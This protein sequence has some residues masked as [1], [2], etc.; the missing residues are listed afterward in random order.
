MF[1]R[2]HLAHMSTLPVRSLK[3]VCSDFI[4]AVWYNT[5]PPSCARRLFDVPCLSCLA[6][7]SVCVAIAAF[8]LTY[9]LIMDILLFKRFAQIQLS[10]DSSVGREDEVYSPLTHFSVKG[11]LNDHPSQFIVVPSTEYVDSI[12]GFSNRFITPDVISYSHLLCGFIAG[13]FL[14]SNHLLDRRI[15]VMLYEFRTWLDSLDGTVYRAQ[16]G[17]RL[18]Y[19]SNHS[20]SGYFIDSIFDTFGG[21]FLCLG[22][23]Y[24]LKKRFGVGHGELQANGYKLHS[25]IPDAVVTLDN[26]RTTTES[27]SERYLLWKTFLFGLSLAVAGKCWDLAV[28]DFTNVYEYQFK[29]ESSFSTMQTEYSHSHVTLVIFYLWRLC[30]GQSVLNY[31]LIAIFLDKTWFLQYMPYVFLGASSL[32]YIATCIYLFQVS[33]ALHL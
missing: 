18:K 28:D 13:K 33:S 9:F 27:Y 32:L 29:K 12:L 24:Y 17:L 19:H 23:F 14:A 4:T 3:Y 7:R 10:Q 1:A 21:F 2:T 22:I 30:G 6:R 5:P 31:V 20:S 8:L 26:D 11:L 15:G 16:A 25:N